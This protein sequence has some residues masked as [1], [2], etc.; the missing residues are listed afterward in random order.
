[1]DSRCAHAGG[2]S[3]SS[4]SRL[5]CALLF[6]GHKASAKGERVHLPHPSDLEE[7]QIRL[8]ALQ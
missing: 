6:K 1:M 4:S 2:A 5:C 7:E 3:V 8:V